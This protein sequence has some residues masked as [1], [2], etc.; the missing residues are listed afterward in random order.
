MPG[1]NR[2]GATENRRRHHRPSFNHPPWRRS[3]ACEGPLEAPLDGNC[4]C[5]RVA[6]FAWAL[7]ALS[8]GG[9]R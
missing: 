7:G 4:V 9:E 1:L 8:L 5:V 6:W 3:R 2:N